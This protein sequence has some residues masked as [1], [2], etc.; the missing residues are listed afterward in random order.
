MW[1]TRGGEDCGGM[2]DAKGLFPVLFEE[3]RPLET[4]FVAVE[5]D[6][7]I[8]SLSE[9]GVVV[10]HLSQFGNLSSFVTHAQA[11]SCRL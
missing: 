10:V 9:V 5:Q 8:G 4:G 1:G 11:H 7:A 3:R 2:G 6:E